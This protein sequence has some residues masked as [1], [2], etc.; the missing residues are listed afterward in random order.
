MCSLYGTSYTVML[1]LSYLSFVQ[2]FELGYQLILKLHWEG[3]P[4]HHGARQIVLSVEL[5]SQTESFK[6]LYG[7]LSRRVRV[8]IGWR[9]KGRSL[10]C[11]WKSVCALPVFSR[12]WIQND[13]RTGEKFA[14]IKVTCRHPDLSRCGEDTGDA[15]LVL[16]QEVTRGGGS[17][18]VEWP[19]EQSLVCLVSIYHTISGALF[20]VT[21]VWKSPFPW[22]S[23]K[24]FHFP[25]HRSYI[26][27]VFRKSKHKRG[28][29]A[30]WN[31]LQVAT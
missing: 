31:L 10:W 22:N 4:L 26:P 6:S 30:M 2:C 17:L 12:V 25:E 19:L 9:K 24:F 11:Y 16:L 20:S 27:K 1:C 18:G 29:G 5:F 8:S 23:D 28:E 21:S 13:E 15:T 7:W 3:N 14:T